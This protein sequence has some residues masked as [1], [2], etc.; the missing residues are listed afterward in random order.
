MD[1]NAMERGPC[2]KHKQDICKSVR[3][4][5][6]SVQPSSLV[7]DIQFHVLI[8]LSTYFEI[9]LVVDLLPTTGP[10]G[11]VLYPISKLSFPSF[12]QVLRI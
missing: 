10:P 7:P 3:Y 8:L 4:Q 2:S 6:L 5:M 12:S 9:P 11:A 1:H